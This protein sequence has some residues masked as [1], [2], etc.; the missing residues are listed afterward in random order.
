VVIALPAPTFVGEAAAEPGATDRGTYTYSLDGRVQDLAYVDAL[1]A[2]DAALD[3]G[4]LVDWYLNVHTSM[5]PAG[6]VRGQLSADATDD[7]GLAGIVPIYQHLEFHDLGVGTN[8]GTPQTSFNLIFDAW[9]DYPEATQ[10][11][12][13][14]EDFTMTRERDGVVETMEIIRVRGNNE[15][16]QPYPKPDLRL[17]LDTHD[18]IEDGDVVTVTVLDSGA[19]KLLP[20]GRN[21]GAADLSDSWR[22][23]C[24]HVISA[25]AFTSEPCGTP[26]PQPGLVDPALSPI[27]SAPDQE[28]DIEVTIEAPGLPADDGGPVDG[29]DEL[30]I[31]LLPVTEEGLVDYSDAAWTAT[32]DGVELGTVEYHLYPEVEHDGTVHLP[33]L[34]FRHTGAAPVDGVLELSG[35]GIDGSDAAVH[36]EDTVYDTHLVR[37]DTGRVAYDQIAVTYV[38]QPRISLTPT[39]EVRLAGAGATHTTEAIHTDVAGA[40]VAGA[41]IEF[42]AERADGTVVET[43]TVTTAADGT[44]S[45]TSTYAGQAPLVAGSPEIDTV[46]AELVSDRFV[47]AHTTVIWSAGVAT[48]ERTEATFHDLNG[49]IVAAAAGDTITADGAFTSVYGSRRDDKISVARNGVG[50]PLTGLTLLAGEDGATLTGALD[51]RADGVVVDGFTLEWAGNK[52]YVVRIEGAGI[53]ITDNDIDAA[54]TNGINVRDAWSQVPGGGSARIAGNTI[55]DAA[56]GIHVDVDK[57]KGGEPVPFVLVTDLTIT[58]NTIN[59]TDTGIYYSPDAGSS[60]DITGNRFDAGATTTVYVE[61]A[62]LVEDDVALDLGA[63]LAA[64]TYGPEGEVLGRRIVP[65]DPAHEPSMVRVVEHGTGQGKQYSIVEYT[66]GV[67]CGADGAEVGSQFVLDRGTDKTPNRV[68]VAVDCD[69]A[70]GQI[71]ITWDGNPSFPNEIHYVEHADPA[72]RIHNEHPLTPGVFTDAVSPDVVGSPFPK[73]ED[74]IVSGA[75]YLTA[76]GTTLDGRSFAQDQEIADVDL[77]VSIAS[78]SE[79]ATLSLVFDLAR[80]GEQFV[81]ADA[82]CDE[83]FTAESCTTI[84]AA[85]EANDGFSDN[86]TFLDGATLRI[87]SDAPA[88]TWQLR[89]SVADAGTGEVYFSD[90]YVV[91]IA[92]P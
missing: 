44:A 20:S 30:W 66:R 28:Q 6:E 40:P 4:G 1:G 26:Q 35:T 24:T 29:V 59:D 34:V 9:I 22:T 48:N 87:A 70:P 69:H 71:E 58:G 15:D 19:A 49:A 13:D 75:V 47:D 65:I 37:L 81:A 8:T 41:A 52:E 92:I 11:W 64:N 56:I 83:L 5:N 86:A 80:P 25:V 74:E 42:T 46:R 72:F 78:R 14:P 3:G 90:T 12:P 61:D 33:Y 68:G 53:E 32:V 31:D 67:A 77:N 73:P 82:A 63:I 89:W 43:E 2:I 60:A 54:G 51:V 57:V 10:D 50:Q 62:T 55:T 16:W 27:E 38:P 85:L 45:F 23:R 79:P 36:G 88:G 17:H 39:D 84:A 21:G 7:G 18:V 91:T 76:A